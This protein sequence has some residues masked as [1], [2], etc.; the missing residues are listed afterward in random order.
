MISRIPTPNANV[1]LSSWPVVLVRLTGA[2]SDDEYRVAL[3]RLRT[4]RSRG[5]HHVVVVDARYLEAPPTGPSDA[6]IAKF[7]HESMARG[8][9]GIR[10]MVVVATF[11]AIRHV[12]ATLLPACISIVGDMG[13]GLA[14]AQA[15]LESDKPSHFNSSSKGRRADR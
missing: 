11:P 3:G 10:G 13:S 5:A 7:W 8:R 4:L 2:P 1:Y 6:R 12:F 14:R 15:L 9:L